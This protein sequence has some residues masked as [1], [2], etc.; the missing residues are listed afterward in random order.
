MRGHIAI[1]VSMWAYASR[2]G[3]EPAERVVTG[4]R[5]VIALADDDFVYPAELATLV[6]KHAGAFEAPRLATP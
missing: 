5:R 1:V 4:S 2:V 6:S 3:A